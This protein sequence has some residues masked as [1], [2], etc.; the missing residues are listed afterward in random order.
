M[1]AELAPGGSTDKKET[2]LNSYW[3]IGHHVLWIPNKM[4]EVL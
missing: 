3:T 1:G 2:R 4:N